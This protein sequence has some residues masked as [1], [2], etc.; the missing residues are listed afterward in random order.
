MR[1]T[2]HTT[3]IVLNDAADMSDDVQYMPAFYICT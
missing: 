2:A 1:T 3:F